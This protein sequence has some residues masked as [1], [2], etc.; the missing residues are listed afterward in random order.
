MPMTVG[1]IQ[2]H[3]LALTNE[4]YEVLDYFTL[5]DNPRILVNGS[6]GSGKTQCAVYIAQELAAEGKRVLLVCYNKRLARHLQDE[7][8]RC[9]ALRWPCSTTTRRA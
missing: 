4:Q 7:M 1:Q 2:R 5:N 8:A 9:R 3:M 6:A